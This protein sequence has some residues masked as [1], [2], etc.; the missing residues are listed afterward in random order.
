MP[1]WK[2]TLDIA[3]Q[4]F[5]RLVAI[6]HVKYKGWLCA[7]DCGSRIFVKGGALTHGQKSCGCVQREYGHRTSVTHGRSKS[8]E[9]RSW[10][11]AIQRCNN[12]KNKRYDD[13][14]GRGINVYQPW[15]DSFS[16]FFAYLGPRPS[17]TTLD[18]INND[19]N[20]EPGN[21]RWATK[22]EQYANQRHTKRITWKGRT[23]TIGDWATE[24]GLKRDALYTRVFK[25][26]WP[27]DRAMMAVNFRV[28]LPRTARAEIHPAP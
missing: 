14:G 13:Y 4:R 2:K 26:G 27:L 19:G 9:F 1:R 17:G 20:Y 5:N 25:R 23:Q 8:P 24:L 18:R 15:A 6:E 7:C 11:G 21:V 12:P 16:A 3:G 28:K 10:D 22:K